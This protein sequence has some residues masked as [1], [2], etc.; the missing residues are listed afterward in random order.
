MVELLECEAGAD[1][2][3]IEMCGQ[4]NLIIANP[5]SHDTQSPDI[6]GERVSFILGPMF[7][8]ERIFDRLPLR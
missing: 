1:S 5:A 8:A 4:M 3:E 6:Q 2:N 7:W